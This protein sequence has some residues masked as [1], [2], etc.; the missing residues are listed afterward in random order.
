VRRTAEEVLAMREAL[1]ARRQAAA[2]TDDAAFVDA[3]IALHAAVVA[4]AGNPVLDDLFAEFVPALRQGLTD[5][6]ELLGPRVTDANHGDAAH[7]A[8]VEAVDAGDGA[9]AAEILRT[10]LDQTLAR[11][12]RPT[13]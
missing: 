4:A 6:V 7:A 11:L 2:S 5:L 10:E 8:L 9:R 12:R 13:T 1:A 3:D